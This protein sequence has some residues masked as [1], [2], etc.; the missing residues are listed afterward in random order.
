MQIQL[1]RDGIRERY[2]VKKLVI[3]AFIGPRPTRGHYIEHLDGDSSN[4]SLV[5]LAWRKRNWGGSGRKLKQ[6]RN[7]CH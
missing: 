2:D 5:N 1:C 7:G 4:C 6:P 3:E